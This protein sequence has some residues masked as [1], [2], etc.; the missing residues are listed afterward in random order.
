M[1]AMAQDKTTLSGLDLTPERLATFG[2]NFL[3]AYAMSVQKPEWGPLFC[4]EHGGH[5]KGGIGK[6]ACYRRNQASGL[7]EGWCYVCKTRITP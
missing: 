6:T 2:F 4:A 3:N 5:C 7:L 1:T